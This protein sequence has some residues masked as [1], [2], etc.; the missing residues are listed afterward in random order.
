MKAYKALQA[1]WDNENT[2]AITI[3]KENSL[4]ISSYSF[5]LIITAYEQNVY[6]CSL[7][8][9]IVSVTNPCI[10]HLLH[11]PVML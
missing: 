6:M 9:S 7:A 3:D 10:V 11:I 1:Q 2:F 8:S 4:V 5:T